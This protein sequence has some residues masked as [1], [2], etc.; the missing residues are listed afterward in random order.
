VSAPDIYVNEWV[1][2]STKDFP[3]NRNAVTG[4]TV[5]IIMLDVDDRRPVQDVFWSDE[6]YRDVFELA[7][8]ATAGVHRPFGMPGEPFEWISEERVSP[9]CIYVLRKS[10]LDSPADLHAEG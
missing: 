6:A 10:P 5:Q 1:S 4:D 8:L 7:G 9:W 2:F 3:E